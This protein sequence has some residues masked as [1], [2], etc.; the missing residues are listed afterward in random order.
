MLCAGKKYSEGVGDTLIFLLYRIR[1][2]LEFGKAWQHLGGELVGQTQVS[3][4]KFT[5]TEDLVFSHPVDAHFAA[6]GL[7]VG[8]IDFRV[9][10][11]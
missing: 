8:Q 1:W 3:Y 2:K 4:G 11:I 5:I 6:T 9:I 7:Q 10:E